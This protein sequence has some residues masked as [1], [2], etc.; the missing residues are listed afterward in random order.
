MRSLVLLMNRNERRLR[1]RASAVTV[2]GSRRRRRPRRR[3]RGE[4]AEV[5]FAS[6]AKIEMHRYNGQGRVSC[7]MTFIMGTQVI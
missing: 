5:E 7:E 3:A 4:H 6:W 1:P 2:H